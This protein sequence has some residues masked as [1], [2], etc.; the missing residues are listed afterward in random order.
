MITKKTKNSLSVCHSVF[1][2]THINFNI[3][4]ISRQLIEKE[5]LCF[6]DAK[7]ICKVVKCWKNCFPGELRCETTLATLIRVIP[8][9]R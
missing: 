5:Q 7:K 3:F 9:I 8:R 6:S 1:R 4:F 2:Q